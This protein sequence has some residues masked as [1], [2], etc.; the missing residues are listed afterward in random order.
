M[1]RK[2]FQLD[3]GDEDYDL[4]PMI[5]IVFL[6]IAFFMVVAKMIDDENI[7]LKLPIADQASIPEDSPHRST[8]NVTASGD[9]Y[10]GSELVNTPQEVTRLVTSAR[11]AKGA[12]LELYLRGD[13]NTPHRHIQS[14]MKAI[15]EGGVYQVKFGAFEKQ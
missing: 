7:D 9:I 2:K 4:T 1:A 11:Q 10:W 3:T 12:E 6:L 15:A 5:D 8:I 13:V 14:V